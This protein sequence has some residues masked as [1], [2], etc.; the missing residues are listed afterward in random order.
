MVNKNV[1]LNNIDNNGIIN[2]PMKLYRSKGKNTLLNHKISDTAGVYFLWNKYELLYIGKA[3]NLKMRIAQHMG[4]G[5]TTIHMVNPDEVTK[6]SVIYTKDEFDAE[7]LEKQLVKLIPTKFNNEPFYERDWYPDWK[8][9]RG[10][11]DENLFK[12]K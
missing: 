3:K 2:I 1:K 7:R 8:W 5:F 9:G 10:A 11:F 6:V 12:D 4:R